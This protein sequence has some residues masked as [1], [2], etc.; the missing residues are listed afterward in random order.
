MQQ[1]IFILIS[2]KIA[3]LILVSTQPKS[4]PNLQVFLSI[5]SV[6]VFGYTDER[7]RASALELEVS[8]FMR[9]SWLAMIYQGDPFISELYDS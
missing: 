6:M 2:Y 4:L 1:I 8:G 9:L 7:D 5:P 3:I